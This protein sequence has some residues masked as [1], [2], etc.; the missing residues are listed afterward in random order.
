MKPRDAA[1]RTGME[2]RFIAL[3]AALTL[4]TSLLAQSPSALDEGF[5]KFFLADD[6]ATATIEAEKIVKSGV[7]FDDAWA[8]LKKGRPY[9]FEK[10]GEFSLRWKSSVGPYF[11]N[12]VNVPADYDPARQWPLRVQL[13]G[14]VARPSPNVTRPGESRGSP[15]QNRIAGESQIYAHPSG[16]ADAQW[17]NAEQVENI[18][19]LVDTLK[20]RYN[21]DESRIYITG[22]S[23]GGTGVYYMAMKSPTTW[24]SYLPL[25]GSI[26]VLRSSENGADGELYGN[27]LINA[28]LYIVNGEQ[29]PLYPVWQVEPHIAW[30]K[31][32]GVQLVF[33]PQAGAVHNTAW[34]P[35]ERAPF[36]EFVHAHPRVPHPS[37]LTWE[38]ERADAFNRNRW[39]IIDG[40]KLGGSQDP[41]LADAGFFRHSVRSGRVNI[42]RTGNVFDA[43]TRDVGSFTLLLSPDV[44]DFSKPVTVMVNG[45][46]V[47]QGTVKKDPEVLLRWAARDNDRTMLY[48]AE[49]TI[50][51]PEFQGSKVPGFEFQGSE[52]SGF[53]F[54]GFEG[55]GFAFQGSTR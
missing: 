3:I 10:R 33:R 12:I 37:T 14:G 7:T 18:L 19:R 35:T 23:D 39:L 52:G 11:N 26:A 16:W 43:K 48:G 50:T 25:N 51:V 47:F 53:E 40:L 5:T 34:W 2:R 6:P 17:W 44:V 8:R 46:R 21:I 45:G 15:L 36:E 13:H 54:Q 20:R 38:T 49:L 24:A 30:F 42:T 28:P 32:L 27:N 41:S 4:C 55:S 1:A 9:V 29:D 31:Q 22:I